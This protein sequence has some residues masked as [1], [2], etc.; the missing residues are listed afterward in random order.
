MSLL[1]VIFF[2]FP[3]FKPYD[4]IFVQDKITK[5]KTLE[6]ITCHDVIERRNHITI[7]QETYTQLINVDLIAL[8]NSK[9]VCFMM[10]STRMSVEEPSSTQNA[11]PM[12]TAEVRFELEQLFFSFAQ[13]SEWVD[14]NFNIINQRIVFRR[15]C[16]SQHQQLMEISTHLTLTLV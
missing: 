13:I 5:K 8:V 1:Y 7:L 3:K 9:P 14:V 2:Y 4:F 16:Q 11:V 6:K 15:Q 10:N 12:D